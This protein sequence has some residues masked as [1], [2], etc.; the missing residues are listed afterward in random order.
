MNSGRDRLTNRGETFFPGAGLWLTG[1]FFLTSEWAIIF[2][3]DLLGALGFFLQVPASVVCPPR[4]VGEL[5]LQ[6]KIWVLFM[7]TEAMLCGMFTF[8]AARVLID[9]WQSSDSHR[10]VV[11]ICRVSF[12]VAAFAS[13]MVFMQ[14]PEPR[15]WNYGCFA[16]RI[17]TYFS[18][19]LPIVAVS[20]A[21]AA[22]W[23]IEMRIDG[24]E[25]CP[26]RLAVISELLS[27]RHRV[28][29]LLAGASALLVLGVIS[30]LL[31]RALIESLAPANPFPGESVVY[32]G[33]EYTVLVG[34][35]YFPVHL[36]LG[37]VSANF[38]ETILSEGEFLSA[39]EML[40]WSTR[41]SALDEL[42]HLSFHE[43]K[44]FGPGFAISAPVVMG[45]LSDLA[46]KHIS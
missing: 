36:S 1:A 34:F 7:L 29:S 20:F 25:R 44:N 26:P 8:S 19:F 33:F 12:R 45:I 13:I 17:E 23:F 4:P 24:L 14:V 2:R 16:G 31:R 15:H 11:R 9:L 40:Q 28:Q 41:G 21:A 46:K 37:A 30:I 32:Q 38:R 42:L 43:W 22:M 6:T 27:Y 39:S 3:H 18:G 10:R 5:F 35:A